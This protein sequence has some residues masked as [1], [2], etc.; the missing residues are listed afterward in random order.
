MTVDSFARSIAT[1]ISDTVSDRYFESLS[2]D[3]LGCERDKDE[4]HAAAVA[5]LYFLSLRV[6]F[7]SYPD[8][9]QYIEE[10]ARGIVSTLGA[11]SPQ[12]LKFNKW[13]QRIFTAAEQRSDENAHQVAFDYLTSVLAPNSTGTY[14]PAEDMALLAGAILMQAEKTQ[15]KL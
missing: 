8:R 15:F 9:S 6:V 5:L 2:P 7:T 11:E 10:L 3:D 4:I 14:K 1:Q 13:T 12:C